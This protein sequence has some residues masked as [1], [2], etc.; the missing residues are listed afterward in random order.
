MQIDI[1][2]FGPAAQRFGKRAVS[3]KL[4]GDSVTCV[5]LRARL[6][7]AAPD[8][9]DMLSSHRLAVNHEFASDDQQIRPGDEVALIGLVSGG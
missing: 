8:I 6:V 2:L 3:L 5:T 7:E 1:Q 9:A 4:D